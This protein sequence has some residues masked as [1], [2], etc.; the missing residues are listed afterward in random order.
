MKQELSLFEIGDFVTIGGVL[1]YVLSK[2][3]TCVSLLVR[4]VLCRHGPHRVF[5]FPLHISAK[6]FC[7]RVN[8][9]NKLADL[10][11]SNNEK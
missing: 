8:A 1:F 5:Y 7:T 3:E 11:K 4:H 10:N 9:Y 2:N 6:L